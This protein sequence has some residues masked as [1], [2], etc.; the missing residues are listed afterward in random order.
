MDAD[1][2]TIEAWTCRGLRRFV[3]LFVLIY[4]L[5]RCRSAGSLVRRAACG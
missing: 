1:F 2:F 5:G 3:V 4:R